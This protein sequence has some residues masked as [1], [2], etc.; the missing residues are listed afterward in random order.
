M[1]DDQARINIIC[2]REF[3]RAVKRAIGD[4]E[5]DKLNEGYLKIME[6]GLEEFKKMEVKE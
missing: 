1:A 6:R 4:N 3:K 5:I 2:S